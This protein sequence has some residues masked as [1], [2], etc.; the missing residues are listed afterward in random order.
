MPLV[1]ISLQA[2]KPAAYRRQVADAVHEALVETMDVPAADRFQIL[3]EHAADMLIV[4]RHYLGIERSDDVVI[5]QI[6]L[7]RGRTVAQKQALY[8][9]IAERLHDAV[10]LRPEDAFVALV[11]NELPDWSFGLGVAQY[12]KAA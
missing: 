1:R 2:G 10:G 12:V 9:R 8:R 5:V 11:E 4:D 7:R 3:T 6:H